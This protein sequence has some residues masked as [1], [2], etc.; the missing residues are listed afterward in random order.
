MVVWKYG[1][2]MEGWWPGQVRGTHG[3]GLW[4]AIMQVFDD[5]I[6]EGIFK[7]EDERRMRF[8]QDI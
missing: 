8:W 4:K 2:S 1:V 6:K 3:L 7:I 5:F